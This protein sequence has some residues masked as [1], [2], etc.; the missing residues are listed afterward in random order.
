MIWV[1]F[2]IMTLG[3]T[4]LVY[5]P[6]LNKSNQTDIE[7]NQLLGIYRSQLVEIKREEKSGLLSS[8]ETK[9][10]KLE[11]ERRLLK[12]SDKKGRLLYNGGVLLPLLLTVTLIVSGLFFYINTGNPSLSSLK[13]SNGALVNNTQAI[14]INEILR[15][16]EAHLKANPND[17][18]AWVLMAQ[19]RL[20][21]GKYFEASNAFARAYDLSDNDLNLLIQQGE[22]LIN[23]AGGQLTPASNL[24]FGT[25][26][27]LNPNHPAPKYY[28]G[29]GRYQGGNIEGAL[30]VWEQLLLVSD[31]NNTW[32]PNLKNQIER[33]KKELGV[34]AA[35]LENMTEQEQE[36]FIE[37]MIASLREKLLENPDDLEG[38]LR[39][40]R[41]EIV[42]GRPQFG[43]EALLKAEVLAD[44]DLKIQITQEISKLKTE[45]N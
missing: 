28:L 27:K 14:E 10:A 45:L 31:E 36:A 38:W 42:K 25:A 33:A 1:I 19:S 23:L 12:A 7:K 17:M 29:L 6:L 13:K 26:M 5:F 21:Q 20:K 15:K 39:L 37:S 16:M 43:L 34:G 40:A 30:E 11:V 9:A 2:T 35:N 22:A 24:A 3:A 8:K 44:G 41:S 18:E 32:V 4:L